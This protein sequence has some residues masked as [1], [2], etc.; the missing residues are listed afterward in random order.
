MAFDMSASAF[1]LTCPV[2]AGPMQKSHERAS[3]C[4]YICREC[5]CDLNVPVTSWDVARQKR[6]QVSQAR[7]YRRWWHRRPAE[8]RG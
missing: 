2:C 5:E 4:W 7:E 1:S 8:E 3:R 6:E